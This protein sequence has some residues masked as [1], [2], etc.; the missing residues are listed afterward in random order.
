[1]II[2]SQLEAAYNFD[3]D[4]TSLHIHERLTEHHFN[5]DPSSKMRNHLAEDVLNK[6]MHY[7]MI[8]S[9]NFN[10][11]IKDPAVSE[12]MMHYNCTN[13]LILCL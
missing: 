9:D 2:W 4:F 13:V 5:L 7:L 10:T 6:S 8:V 1:M 3:Q 11:A 12:P